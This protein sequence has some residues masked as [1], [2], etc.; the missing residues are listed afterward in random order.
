MAYDEK[1][2]AKVKAEYEGGLTAQGAM[3][4][5]FRISRNTL[6]KFAKKDGWEFGKN[7]KK[8]TETITKK[9]EAKLAEKY[10]NDLEDFTID[11]IKSMDNV[12]A[13]TKATLNRLGASVKNTK[14]TM[15]KADADAIF[16]QAKILKISSETLSII[17]AD[18]RKALGLDKEQKDT[19]VVVNTAPATI[20][21]EGIDPDVIPE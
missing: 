2:K 14:N 12:G 18:K 8:L 19:G 4:Q 20:I 5:K 3:C 1:F 13:L 6:K 10:S 7:D 16:A 11:H 15:S 17:Y 9:T 21:I